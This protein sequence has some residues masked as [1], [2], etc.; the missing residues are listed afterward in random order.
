MHSRNELLLQIVPAEKV[1]ATIGKGHRPINQHCG[2]DFLPIKGH[3][4]DQDNAAVGCAVP[5]QSPII[6]RI[7]T[8]EHRVNARCIR[9][10]LRISFASHPGIASSRDDEASVAKA[11]G[12]IR[13]DALIEIDVWS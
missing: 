6:Q 5:V 1:R 4:A 8:D 9:E 10:L 12:E 3:V 7:V 11:N 2:P 13:V